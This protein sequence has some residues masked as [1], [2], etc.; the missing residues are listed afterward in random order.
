MTKQEFS[1]NIAML[2]I[3]TH[4]AAKYAEWVKKHMGKAYLRQLAY[5][6]ETVN[7]KVQRDYINGDTE[8]Q[9]VYDNIGAIFY[10]VLEIMHNHPN[11]RQEF[12]SFL[13][14]YV[15]GEIKVEG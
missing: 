2:A 11:K 1:N 6:I 9:E 12:I 5:D 4:E 10:D 13:K 3:H 8:A 7:K 14:A 15:D